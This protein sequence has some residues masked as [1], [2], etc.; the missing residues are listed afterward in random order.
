MNESDSKFLFTPWQ[1]EL[2]QN[3]VVYFVKFY[4]CVLYC[5]NE[6]AALWKFAFWLLLTME[7]ISVLVLIDYLATWQ[8]VFLLNTSFH[9]SRVRTFQ[10]VLF[11]GGLCDWSPWSRVLWFMHYSHCGF[12]SFVSPV[13]HMDLHEIIFWRWKGYQTTICMVWNLGWLI[14]QQLAL[15]PSQAAKNLS[16][17]GSFFGKKSSRICLRN[18][19]VASVE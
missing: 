5:K 15:S 2:C 4:K 9:Q 1:L 17:Q 11:E 3:G 16:N 12:R 13:S 19:A 8:I 7:E 6:T 18:A 10:G 14:M